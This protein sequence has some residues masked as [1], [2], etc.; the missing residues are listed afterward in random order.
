MTREFSIRQ[1][2][3]WLF[4]VDNVLVS[5][6]EQ[7]LVVLDQIVVATKDLEWADSLD[8]HALKRFWINENWI[9]RQDCVYAVEIQD[10]IIDIELIQCSPV[11]QGLVAE[12]TLIVIVEGIASDNETAVISNNS[13]DFQLISSPNSLYFPIADLPGRTFELPVAL[14]LNDESKNTIP[15]API[16]LDTECII[17]TSFSILHQINVLSG[18]WVRIEFL[19]TSGSCF[20]TYKI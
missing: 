18:S 14:L 6:A 10:S 12:S 3:Q 4:D 9:A 5:V 17:I 1:N 15:V 19:Y 11:R 7:P 13:H 16:D 2:L 20:Y 8:I